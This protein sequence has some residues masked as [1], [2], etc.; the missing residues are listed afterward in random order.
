M[1]IISPLMTWQL[2]GATTGWKRSPPFLLKF[3][4]RMTYHYGHLFPVWRLRSA[5]TPVIF[6]CI[7]AVPVKG[8]PGKR[9][10]LSFWLRLGIPQQEVTSVNRFLLD[11]GVLRILYTV[12][13]L[14]L[15]YVMWIQRTL[16]LKRCL[17]IHVSGIHTTDAV[18]SF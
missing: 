6:L 1:R 17:N 18:L 15:F 9:R 10:N 16:L 8:T 11:N 7:P 13:V 12:P 4:G 2:T 3:D 14:N 5:M